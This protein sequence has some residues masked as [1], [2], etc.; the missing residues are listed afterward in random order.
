MTFTENG[1]KVLH[2]WMP[3]AMANGIEWMQQRA[4]YSD[5][6]D[7]LYRNRFS[8]NA[9][10]WYLGALFAAALPNLHRVCYAKP[11]TQEGASC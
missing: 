10:L 5:K 1:T 4:K 7:C 6:F 11:L 2:E 8:L 9:A 3:L